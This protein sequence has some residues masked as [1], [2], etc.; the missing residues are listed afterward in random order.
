MPLINYCEV[1]DD[2]IGQ[3]PADVTGDGGT[4]SGELPAVAKGD[5]LVT[6]DNG[7]Q[8]IT[9][10]RPAKYN[11]ITLE[12][13][14]LLQLFTSSPSSSIDVQRYNGSPQIIGC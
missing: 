4:S 6:K 12:V 2:L 7:V 3:Q 13:E 1:V 9:L 8:T 11:A 10:N 14:L 5:I